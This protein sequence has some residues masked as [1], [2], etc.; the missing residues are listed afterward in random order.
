MNYNIQRDLALGFR[1]SL[2]VG[3]RWGREALLPERQ[4]PSLPDASG[5]A[6]T[7]VCTCGILERQGSVAEATRG[8]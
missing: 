4:R 8:K 2:S 7:R 5:E 1:R 6:E 3:Q